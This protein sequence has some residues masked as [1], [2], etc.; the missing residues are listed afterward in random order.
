MRA[1]PPVAQ[2]LEGFQGCPQA[3]VCVGCAACCCGGVGAAAPAPSL[4]CVCGGC[5]RRLPCR[6]AATGVGVAG[7]AA[8][9]AR[10]SGAHMLICH[11]VLIIYA[12]LFLDGSKLNSK[13]IGRAYAYLPL[14]SYHV[15]S[16]FPGILDGS[17]LNSMAIGRQR[18]RR[19]IRRVSAARL[20]HSPGFRCGAG[21]RADRP[22]REG[23]GRAAAR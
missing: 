3:G 14:G 18:G 19:T 10:R 4:R 1:A 5:W 2:G 20:Q 7:A 17:K 6:S 21:R 22:D 8:L 15:R 12:A 9:S 11:W 23:V 13:P 16:P